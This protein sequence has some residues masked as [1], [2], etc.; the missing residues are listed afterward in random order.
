MTGPDLTTGWSGRTMGKVLM[1]VL[2][3]AAQPERYASERGIYAQKQ[4]GKHRN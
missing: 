3:G 2:C 4:T 1:A